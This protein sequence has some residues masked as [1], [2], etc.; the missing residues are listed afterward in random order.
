MYIKWKEILHRFQHILCKNSK[1]S[2][3]KTPVL[4]LASHFYA[5]P[6]S[7]KFMILYTHRS[8]LFWSGYHLGN[9]FIAISYWRID[10]EGICFH[11]IKT[12]M[13]MPMFWNC[14]W[15]ISRMEKYICNTLSF[16]WFPS[17]WNHGK[18][19]RTLSYLYF[20]AHSNTNSTRLLTSYLVILEKSE[21]R[22][23]MSG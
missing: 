20:H 5:S 12:G 22:S 16:M 10:L 17:S 4:K 1:E 21:L 9:H 6:F 7:L 13:V 3:I 15:P 19:I 11:P 18:K 2:M 14:S 8:Y 23:E